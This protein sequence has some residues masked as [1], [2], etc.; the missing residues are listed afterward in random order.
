MATERWLMLGVQ[1]G[2]DRQALHGVIRGHA[3]AAADQAA[4]GGPNDLLER[5]AADPAFAAVD[6]DRLQAELDPRRYVGRAPEQV[7]EFVTEYLDPLVARARPHA[8]K[9]DPAELRV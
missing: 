1:A 9:A 5:L 8:V 3:L 7:A 2:G 4:T 6:P